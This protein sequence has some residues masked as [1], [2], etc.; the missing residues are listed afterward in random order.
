MTTSRGQPPLVT[1]TSAHVILS[2]IAD[3]HGPGHGSRTQWSHGPAMLL[4]VVARLGESVQSRRRAGTRARVRVR[5]STRVPA[6]LCV[7]LRAYVRARMSTCVLILRLVRPMT[8][9]LSISYTSSA[10]RKQAQSVRVTQLLTN[11]Q[12]PTHSASRS[13]PVLSTNIRIRGNVDII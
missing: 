2:E 10:A 5:E 13:L 4:Q 8:S 3:R 6:H 7:L 12:P 9:T 11:T 1:S